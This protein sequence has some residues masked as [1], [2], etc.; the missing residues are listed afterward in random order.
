MTFMRMTFFVTATMFAAIIY[1]PVY[2]QLVD[3]VSAV[4]RFP[5]HFHIGLCR[6]EGSDSL[7][8]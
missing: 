4:G 5:N 8:E 7:T 1:I 6:D 2:L 3:G